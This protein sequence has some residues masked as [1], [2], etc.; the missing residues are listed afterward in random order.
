[1]NDTSTLTRDGDWL[2]AWV[3]DELVMMSGASGQCISVSETGGRIWDLLDT[4][5]TVASLCDRLAAEYTVAG[6][7]V[8]GEV[9]GFLHQLRE[10]GAI[11]VRA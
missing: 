3:G 6:V 8:R 11:H 2:V 7:D 10:Q 1:M 5:Q 4:P 9:V